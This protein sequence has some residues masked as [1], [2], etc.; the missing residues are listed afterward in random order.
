VLTR[1]AAAEPAPNQ[2]LEPTR[3]P[4][5]LR[6]GVCAVHAVMLGGESPPSRCTWSRRTREAQG[7]HREV[8]S[9]GS[10]ERTCGARDTNRIRGVVQPGRAGTQQQSPPSTIGLCFINPASMHGRYDSLP[11]EICGV[12]CE[13]LR[14]EQ[15]SLTTSQKSADGI[16]GPAQAKLVRHPKAE[17]RGNG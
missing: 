10:V 16:V 6:P 3:W 17:R 2:G 8:E 14:A 5:R 1:S 11:R 15:S 12:S 7:R 4:A 13:G 9:E